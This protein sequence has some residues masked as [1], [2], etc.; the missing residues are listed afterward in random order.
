MWTREYYSDAQST[1]TTGGC[2]IGVV[3]IGALW[4]W[5]MPVVAIVIACVGVYVDCLCCPGCCSCRCVRRKV[6]V[7]FDSDENPLKLT[8]STY[9]CS[10]G[11]RSVYLYSNQRYVQYSSSVTSQIRDMYSTLAVLFI[12]KYDSCVLLSHFARIVLC[13]TSGVWCSA[14]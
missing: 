5:C 2:N 6:T 12:L 7:A 11:T 4:R 1:E 9:P 13:V 10:E 3:C 8:F 14:L